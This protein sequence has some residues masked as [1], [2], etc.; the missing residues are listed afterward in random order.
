[1]ERGALYPAVHCVDRVDRV[2]QEIVVHDGMKKAP[3]FGAWR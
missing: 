1:V 2:E 3:E